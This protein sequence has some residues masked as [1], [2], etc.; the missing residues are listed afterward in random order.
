M[1]GAVAANAPGQNS[2]RE[3]EDDIWQASLLSGVLFQ[4]YNI[5]AVRS[6]GRELCEAMTTD[7][8]GEA[9]RQ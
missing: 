6:E 3:K 4:S 1:T 9:L 8:C 5:L 7:C 2:N